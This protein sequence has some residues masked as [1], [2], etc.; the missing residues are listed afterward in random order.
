VISLQIDLR[1]SDPPAGTVFVVNEGDRPI[2]VWRSGNKWAD[3][4]LFFELLRGHHRHV[5]RRVGAVYTRN[6]PSS[7]EIAPGARLGLEFDVGDGT[8]DSESLIFADGRL[9]AI[10][11][12]KPSPEAAASRVWTGRLRAEVTLGE[13]SD[14]TP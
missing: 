14:E 3:T 7:V 1:R 4:S 6:V 10:Y 11:E 2:R 12:I 9:V 13:S 8:W 5:L